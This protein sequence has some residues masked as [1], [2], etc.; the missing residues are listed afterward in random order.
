MKE[1]DRKTK[2]RT[3]CLSVYNN[4]D[5][6]NKATIKC[7]IARLTLSRWLNHVK[8]SKTYLIIPID[9]RIL[10]SLRSFKALAINERSAN[11]R[12]IATSFFQSS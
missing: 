1:K 3:T 4:L 2:T 10:F 8:K 5:S 11:M 6:V 7:G 9:Q 12:F